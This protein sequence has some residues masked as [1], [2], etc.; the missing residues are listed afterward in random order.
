[1]EYDNTN[2][3]ALFNAENQKLLRSG[4]VNINGNDEYMAIVQS[5]TRSGKTIFEVFQ[6]VGVVF[7]NEKRDENDAD[8]SGN[9]SNLKDGLE[10]KIWGRKRES[11]NGNPFT[12][13]SLAEATN[14]SPYPANSDAVG[15][16]PTNSIPDEEIPF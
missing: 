12:S 9:I 16:I 4:P 1:M 3:G 7:P 15:Q 8:M 6:K 10:M 5:K 11:K 2:S 13:I 14:K